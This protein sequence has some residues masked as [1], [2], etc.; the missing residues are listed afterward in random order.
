M[1]KKLVHTGLRKTAFL[2]LVLLI[3]GRFSATR[4]QI[5]STVAAGSLNH[6]TSVAVDGAGN[7]LICDQA[8]NRIR[9]VAPN[10]IVST[11]AG[12][13][14]GG[15]WGDGMPATN[16]EMFPEAIA[17]DAAANIYIADRPNAR[18]RKVNTA[19]IINTVVGNGTVGFFGEGIPATN[20][21]IYDSRTVAVDGAGNIFIADA[22]NNVI[23]KVNTAGFISTVGG[24]RTAGFL[25]D[26]GTATDA[27]LNYP[28]HI[29]VDTKGNIFFA[30]TKNKRVRKID[31]SGMITTF[32]GNGSDG[33]SG[34][35][36]PATNA[37][38]DSAGGI[39]ED[40]Y[41]NVYI[42]D[43]WNN[44]IRMVDKFGTITTVAGLG[45]TGFGGGAWTGDGGPATAAQLN[46][47]DGLSIGCGGQLY[48]ADY[49]NNVVRVISHGMAP[50]FVSGHTESLTV[51]E[52]SGPTYIDTLLKVNDTDLNQSETWS[53][54]L[55]AV[56]GFVFATYTTVSTSLTLTPSGLLY[57]PHTGFSGMDSFKVKVTD[58]GG[59]SDSTTIYVTVN[60]LP[61]VGSITGADTICPDFI[62]SLSDTTSG[63]AWTSSNT[64]ITTISITGNV[65]G[66]S[67]GLDTLKY[68]LTNSCGTTTVIHPF[69]IRDYTLCMGS[70]DVNANA[71]IGTVKVYPNPS[72][73]SFTVELPANAGV[74]TVTLTDIYGRIVET[75]T[76]SNTVNQFDIKHA[77]SG[78]Y[79]IKIENGT[80]TFREKVNIW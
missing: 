66:I 46:F 32:A 51:C 13:G 37:S 48:I 16:A 9:K 23:R 67:P 28:S 6:P 62:I 36:G 69:V 74:S 79:L 71:V 54:L 30:D 2:L 22:Q 42:A 47:P 3:S 78:T 73:G 39:A 33:Y 38:L 80:G 19:G 10:G 7:L 24:S 20:A 4:A 52:N 26:G 18:I 58:C 1:N 29:A 44:R 17:V 41:G 76:T 59:L 72:S 11:A 43:S 27:Q 64:S 25:G 40:A 68:S 53:T 21:M 49:F 12:S 50:V 75:R 70:L 57:V 35:N 45:P 60:P 56:N 14:V 77:S 55:P 61:V 34:D 63:G 65:T 31:A 8:N 15:F 5:I